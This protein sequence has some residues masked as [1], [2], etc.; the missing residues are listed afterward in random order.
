MPLI[1]YSVSISLTLTFEGAD[2]GGRTFKTEGM[3]DDSIAGIDFLL[4]MSN[5]HIY[6]L[7]QSKK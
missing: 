3:L 5:F 6:S 7:R 2:I 4:I 1:N